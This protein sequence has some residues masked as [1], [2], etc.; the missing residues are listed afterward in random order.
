MEC[1]TPK[2]QHYELKE[3]QK[4]TISCVMRLVGHRAFLK[5]EVL[6]FQ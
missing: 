3:A 1:G 4:F 6:F 2:G 5:E